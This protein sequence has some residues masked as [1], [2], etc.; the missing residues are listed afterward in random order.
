MAS[1]ARGVPALLADLVVLLVRAIIRKC[2][3]RKKSSKKHPGH[4]KERDDPDAFSRV[5][6]GGVTGVYTPLSACGSIDRLLAN[7]REYAFI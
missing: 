3:K 7:G 1:A 5:T 4:L 6:T 2:K